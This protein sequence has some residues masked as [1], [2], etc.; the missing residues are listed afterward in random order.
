MHNGTASLEDDLVALEEMMDSWLGEE[1]RGSSG[2][3]VVRGNRRTASS[4][5]GRRGDGFYRSGGGGAESATDDADLQTYVVSKITG[6]PLVLPPVFQRAGKG[7]GSRAAPVVQR[8][9]KV[10]G[11]Q[12]P[13]EVLGGVQEQR[14]RRQK[15]LDLLRRGAED[16]ELEI[17]RKNRA[18]GWSDAPSSG[19]PPLEKLG[20]RSALPATRVPGAAAGRVG[21]TGS[22]QHTKPS[23]SHLGDGAGRARRNVALFTR[24][25]LTADQRQRANRDRSLQ[26]RGD[27]YST[28]EDDGRPMKLD[29]EALLT[30]PRPQPR[31]PTHPVPATLSPLAKQRSGAMNERSHQQHHDPSGLGGSPGSERSLETL[32]SNLLAAQEGL[33]EENSKL[34]TLLAEE[35]A[36][37]ANATKRLTAVASQQAEVKLRSLDVKGLLEKADKVVKKLSL[38]A[39]SNSKILSNLKQREKTVRELQQMKAAALQR[40]SAAEYAV[41][42]QPGAFALGGEG[43]AVEAAAG[44]DAGFSNVTAKLS[45]KDQEQMRREYDVLLLKRNELVQEIT[46]LT[47]VGKQKVKTMQDLSAKLERE[48]QVAKL[49]LER[50]ANAELQKEISRIRENY[51]KIRRHRQREEQNRQQ[52][53][54]EMFAQRQEKCEGLNQASAAQTKELA[55]MQIAVASAK[56][57]LDSAER[58]LAGIDRTISKNV[59]D[60]ANLERR[61]DSLASEKTKL[62]H[63]LRALVERPGLALAPLE[64]Q[65][66]DERKGLQAQASSNANQ[67]KELMATLVKKEEEYDNM[68]QSARHPASAAEGGAGSNN[69]PTRDECKIA[70]D[71]L[72]DILLEIEKTHFGIRTTSKKLDS[73]KSDFEKQS[74]VK[75]KK[76]ESL[77]RSIQEK[78][79]ALSRSNQRNV[80][81]LE[82][83]DAA[84]RLAS[85]NGVTTR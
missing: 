49:E 18:M 48:K 77:T 54:A 55:S 66:S 14:R 34:L 64:A 78:K 17:Q 73:L 76:I 83:L 29:Y 62:N 80:A 53:R 36:K 16:D 38:K 75:D 41:A 68:K 46:R 69:S 61:L 52:E 28:Q 58:Q 1:D 11:Y 24:S 39:L 37:R 72:K 2:V 56:G 44:P 25:A 3:E 47:S 31:Q 81:L 50:R 22:P 5:D 6:R 8:S 74:D 19:I 35:R 10:F 13:R 32:R 12:D 60:K 43:G 85:M 82:R 79:A 23:T 84:E 45:A 65:Q 30:P 42:N 40:L 71:E 27:G 20:G 4:G 26:R 21:V 51:E 7:A 9:R 67:L 57:D 33:Q 15:Q 59:T 63:E 70:E